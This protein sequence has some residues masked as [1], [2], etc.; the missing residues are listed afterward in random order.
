[1]SAQSMSRLR[2]SPLYPAVVLSCR[3]L[4]WSSRD[5]G[6]RPVLLYMSLALRCAGYTAAHFKSYGDEPGGPVVI[7]ANRETPMKYLK[8]IKQCS[9]KK[10]T[11]LATEGP[12]HQRNKQKELEATRLLV[13]Y[14]PVAII[15][16]GW[17]ESM[18]RAWL[19]MATDCSE[20][21]ERAE[22][23]RVFHLHQEIE[24]LWR[25]EKKY[26]WTSG[27][28]LVRIRNWGKKGSL[29][30]DVYYRPPDQGGPTDEVFLFELEEAS[31]LQAPV[32]LGHFNRPDICWK[33]NTESCRQ[34]ENS[35]SALSITS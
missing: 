20:G 28:L 32:P 22:G 34:S 4:H 23:R 21:L 11:Q 8:G 35:W 3:S 10:V 31:H 17:Y 6:I 18:T 5:S 24:T 25:T 14:D 27:S 33:S 12:L 13:R 29:V 1:M 15:E 16:N 26:P 19:S 7:G 30:V 9:S 2:L